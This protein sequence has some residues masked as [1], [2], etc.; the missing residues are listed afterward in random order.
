MLQFAVLHDSTHLFGP[1]DVNRV[2]YN[3]SQNR[4][5]LFATVRIRPSTVMPL[6]CCLQLGFAAV[7]VY[8]ACL[9]WTPTAVSVDAGRVAKENFFQCVPVHASHPP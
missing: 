8:R 5:D 2:H 1:H 6:C 4:T 7:C 9:A 3:R